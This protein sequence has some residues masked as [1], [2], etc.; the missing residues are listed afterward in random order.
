MHPNASPSLIPAIAPESVQNAQT[1]IPIKTD[2]QA[3][4]IPGSPRVSPAMRPRS[5]PTTTP[6][7]VPIIRPPQNHHLKDISKVQRY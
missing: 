2:A 7:T 6:K 1:P 4:K 5:N 3:G